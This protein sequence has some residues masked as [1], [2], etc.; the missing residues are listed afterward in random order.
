[1]HLVEHAIVVIE[2]WKFGFEWQ[3]K[4]K[5]LRGKKYNNIMELVLNCLI[6]LKKNIM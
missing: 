1:M 6:I 4:E 5:D 3:D 2:S